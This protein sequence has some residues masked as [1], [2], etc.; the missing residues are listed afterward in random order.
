M[1]HSKRLGTA[2]ELTFATCRS[3]KKFA[4][5]FRA[6]RLPLD[7]L[8]CNA[9]AWM[10]PDTLSPTEDGFEVGPELCQIYRN[11]HWHGS[12]VVPLCAP[13]PAC[14]QIRATICRHFAMLHGRRVKYAYCVHWCPSCHSWGSAAVIC[15]HSITPH[16]T[17]L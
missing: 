12:H 8:V 11:N 14:M 17:R 13:Q 5:A 6:K 4:E 9:A 16:P 1:Q 3:V 2:L 15:M 7:I 10:P